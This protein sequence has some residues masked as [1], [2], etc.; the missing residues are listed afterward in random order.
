[1]AR[2]LPFPAL[3]YNPARVRLADHPHQRL[4]LPLGDGDWHGFVA[5]I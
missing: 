1:M 5:S 3:R 2:I 4:E